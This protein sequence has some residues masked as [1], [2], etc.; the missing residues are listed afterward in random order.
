MVIV[1]IWKLRNL[2]WS[3]LNYI[4]PVELPTKVLQ[5][6]ESLARSIQE[7]QQALVH[8]WIG[9]ALWTSLSISD[10]G[11]KDGIRACVMALGDMPQNHCASKHFPILIHGGN[12]ICLLYL[13]RDDWF[14][15]YGNSE[16]N[17]IKVIFERD[18]SGII[19]RQCGVSLIYKQDVDG[20][21]QTNAQ[22]LIES[23][24]EVSI[25]ILT[26]N[27]HLNHHSH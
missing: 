9:F 13:S 20:F 15:K 25:Y 27:D 5:Y 11:W 19:V 21:N 12:R 24:G 7:L 10:I 3:K 1:Q 16:C 17:Q 6:I 2:A 14:A 18:N 23:F 26:G 8:K 22:C 4:S